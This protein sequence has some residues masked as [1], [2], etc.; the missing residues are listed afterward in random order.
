MKCGLDE[1]K[2]GVSFIGVEG[3]S[4]GKSFSFRVALD[5]CGAM[6]RC[7]ESSAVE[8]DLLE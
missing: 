1:I 5:F 6:R 3:M 7:F 2:A 4:T 8:L